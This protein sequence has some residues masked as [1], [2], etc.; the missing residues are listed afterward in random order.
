MT[1]AADRSTAPR[2]AYVELTARLRE[3]ATLASSRATLGWD[4]ETMMPPKAAAFRADELALLSTLEHA[5][6]TD[7][8]IAEL[9]AACEADPGITSD[10]IARASLREIRRDHERATRLP[11]DLVT[12]LARTTSQALEAWRHARQASDFAAFR[13]WLERVLELNVRKAKC[14]G[15]PAG[16]EI[17][18]ALLDEYEPGMTTVAIEATFRPLR[19]ALAPLIA[20]I[21]AA[22]RR[23][24]AA[25]RDVKLPIER[26]VEFNR[27]V[28]EKI[29]FD[30]S[31]G[32]LDVSTHP[33]TEGLAPG[34]T[35][36]TTRY[37]DDQF[38]EALGSTMHEVGHGLYE[39]GLPKEAHHG[40]PLAQAASL[41]I[42]ESQSRM[43]EN[44]VGRSRAFWQWAL[45]QAQRI[46]GNAL[47]GFT[48]DDVYGAVNRV[49]PSLIRVEADE[50]TYNLH[51]ML[52]FDLERAL[53]RGDLAVADLPGAWNERI[54][55]DLGLQV[56]DDRRGC[57]Q[58]IHWS[59]GAIGYFPTYTLGTLYAAQFWEAAQRAMPALDADMAR[60][61]LAPLLAWLRENVHAHGRRFRAA[62][63]CARITGAP[64]SH[65]PMMR[66]LTAKL[67]PLYDLG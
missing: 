37:S 17:Y 67:R 27:L 48:V 15:V 31:A 51:V 21:A 66:H 53:V 1:T 36:I 29:G 30:F 54:R 43:W 11:A 62:E 50:A 56:P 35:R 19:E 42:H 39:Q 47:G 64:L 10:P 22:K 3:A 55:A 23:P 49:E 52:R 13:P 40:H 8:R 28:A 12:E 18:D 44:Q 9:I 16:G 6:I 14:Y 38:T 63:L 2:A 26:Q 24:T 46:F 41:G 20:E 61:E 60:G 7:P 59:S 45:P 34:D 5:R 4:Q 25:S 58:D 65:E 32:R 33:F 57:L